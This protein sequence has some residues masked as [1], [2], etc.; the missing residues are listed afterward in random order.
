VG[1]WFGEDRDVQESNVDSEYRQCDKP[2]FP[3][4][5]DCGRE[6]RLRRREGWDGVVFD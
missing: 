6:Q 2:V 1:Y 5:V 4:Y 3:S